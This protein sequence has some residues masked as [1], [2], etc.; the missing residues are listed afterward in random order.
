MNSINNNNINGNIMNNISSPR[1]ALQQQSQKSPLPP[2]PP[3]L[4][5]LYANLPSHLN[6]NNLSEMNVSSIE[7][8]QND[9]SAIPIPPNSTSTQIATSSSPSIQES[10]KSQKPPV[11]PISTNLNNSP[12][13]N[14]SP[15]SVKSPSS[16]KSPS[17]TVP[18]VSPSS[19][20]SKD[21]TSSYR[22]KNFFDAGGNFEFNKDIYL[23]TLN[24]LRNNQFVG[25]VNPIERQEREKNRQSSNKRY[26][27]NT[28]NSNTNTS[29]NNTM[30]TTTSNFNT[31]SISKSPEMIPSKS[32]A[33][34]PSKSFDIQQSKSYINRP[35]KSFDSQ[36]SNSYIKYPSKSYNKSI[37]SYNSK[38]S[39]GYDENL[40][41]PLESIEENEENLMANPV[42]ASG[43]II[44]KDE[45]NNKLNVNSLS[46]IEEPDISLGSIDNTN[47]SLHSGL[48]N[49]SNV[50]GIQDMDISL[51]SVG[52][53]EEEELTTTE[54][55]N[56]E[57]SS[58]NL[59]IKNN[60][61]NKRI[62]QESQTSS[63]GLISSQLVSS[64]KLINASGP[65]RT[66]FGLKRT[67]PHYFNVP[68]MSKSSSNS[69]TGKN[70]LQTNPKQTYVN[71][72]SSKKNSVISDKE[73]NNLRINLNNFSEDEFNK[74]KINKHN[75]DDILL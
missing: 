53:T 57:G 66:A 43:M 22:Q 71:K 50:D 46:K 17:S 5:S 58:F 67:S 11:S 13:S 29:I 55:G 25:Y 20:S 35:Y 34:H 4:S 24:K 54:V 2:P 26:S 23:Q 38:L 44:S 45:T 10:P 12:S 65:S 47:F 48:P 49:V 51:S 31:N 3:Q 16:I 1:P 14:K 30:T 52:H 72:T 32:Y 19:T 33:T 18:P 63:G 36:P 9:I 37:D 27:N 42:N 8:I 64:P 68:K 7:D 15:S 75:V 21:R 61:K 40:E 6:S 62:S 70:Y 41:P 60:N 74:I 69:L 28:N 39:S 73:D 56:I 59:G